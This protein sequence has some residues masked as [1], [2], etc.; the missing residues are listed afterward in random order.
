MVHGISDPAQEWHMIIYTPVGKADDLKSMNSRQVC[1]QCITIR[2]GSGESILMDN[3]D[4][5]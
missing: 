5:A 3:C 1:N 4:N 2:L